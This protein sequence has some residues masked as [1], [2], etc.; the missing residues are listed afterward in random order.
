ME[1]ICAVLDEVACEINRA[2]SLYTSPSTAVSTT[3]LENSAVL[4]S[5]AKTEVELIALK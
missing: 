2:C 4:D 1:T 5:V 3:V